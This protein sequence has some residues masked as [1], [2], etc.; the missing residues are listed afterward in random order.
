MVKDKNSY[1]MGLNIR[2]TESYVKQKG[3]MIGF[4]HPPVKIY[5][6]RARMPEKIFCVGRNG[7]HFLVQDANIFLV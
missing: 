2:I 1:L 4:P 6:N 5:W 7:L 3:G